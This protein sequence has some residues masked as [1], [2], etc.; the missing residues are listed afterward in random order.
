MKIKHVLTIAAAAVAAL[1]LAACGNKSNAGSSNKTVKI[2]ILQL[3]NQSGLD[4]ARKGFVA[5]LAKE[6][7]KDGKNMKL[8]YVNAQGD[9][10]NLSTM[11]QQLQKDKND[12]NLAIATPAAQALQK[13]DPKTPMLFTAVSA[14]VDA[15]IVSSMTHPDKNTSGVTD[16]V[17]VKGQIGLLHRIAPKAKT[18]GLIYNAAEPNSVIQIKAAKKAIKALGLKSAEKTVAST[19]DVQQTM[20]ALT[21][22]AQ[23]IYIPAD[24]TLAAAMATVGKIAGQKKVPV[25]PAASTMVQDGGL[26]TNGFNYRDLG[27]QAAKQAVK[28]LKGK[29][30]STIP[31]E[32]PAK[33]SVMVNKAMAKK[34]GIDPSSI[35]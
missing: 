13:A 10:A 19:N 34:L 33:V 4:D 17:S 29:K 24:N 27:K 9:Q 12:L 35:K 26:A 8:D 21:G 14:P 22:Q 28:I 2:G 23:A 30:T 16:M 31:V 20:T 11:S 5:E 18:I 1:S 15:G 6:G 3:I 7:Y 25:V 32:K